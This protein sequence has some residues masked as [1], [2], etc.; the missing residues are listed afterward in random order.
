MSLPPHTRSATIETPGDVN[1]DVAD[2]GNALPSDEKESAVAS[3]L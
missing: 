1:E 2:E 3:D